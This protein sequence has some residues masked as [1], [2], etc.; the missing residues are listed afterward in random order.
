M[1]CDWLN[2][3]ILMDSRTRSK[4][5]EH[6]QCFSS[7]LVWLGA[8]ESLRLLRQLVVKGVCVVFMLSSWILEAWNSSMPQDTAQCLDLT[9]IRTDLCVDD[10]S[11]C[12]ERET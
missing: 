7:A 8:L 10:G 9:C 4:G 1:A 2:I 5:L 11:Q 3:C 12:L 6:S